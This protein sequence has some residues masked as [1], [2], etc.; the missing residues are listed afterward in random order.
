MKGEQSRLQGEEL[1]TGVVGSPFCHIQKKKCAF[2]NHN[3]MKSRNYDILSYIMR[4]KLEIMTLNDI[5]LN[6]FDILTRNYDIRSN[7]SR[8]S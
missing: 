7:Y 5:F 3:E 2:V 1:K 8:K 6:I 4:C